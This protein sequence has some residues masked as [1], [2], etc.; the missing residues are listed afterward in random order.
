M[1]RPVRCETR[2]SA[3]ILLALA[4]AGA[5]AAQAHDTPTETMGQAFERAL[6]RMAKAKA[7]GLVFV[8]PAEDAKFD[9]KAA[10]TLAQQLATS[11]MGGGVR[12]EIKTARALM[13]ARVQRLRASQTPATVALR[14]LTV[15][16]VAEAARCGARRGETVVLLGADGKRI[17]GFAID[18]GDEKAMLDALTPDVLAEQTVAPR[19]E[20]VEPAV[21]TLVA[22]YRRLR[23]ALVAG[24]RDGE[25]LPQDQAYELMKDTDRLGGKLTEAAPVLVEFRA[26]RAEFTN[27]DPRFALSDESLPFG[28]AIDKSWDPCP[29]CGMMAV[30]LAQRSTLKLLAQ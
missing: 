13:L 8:L 15:P 4:T 30:P 17:G 25:T 16:I 9:A 6:E 5:V 20:V 2:S 19:R 21:A 28:T 23:A 14:M 10:A 3:S 11:R 22:R 18:L 7:P 1:K 12:V 29:P 26:G 24:K 27:D